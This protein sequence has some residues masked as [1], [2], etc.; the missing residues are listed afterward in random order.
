MLAWRLQMGHVRAAI[1]VPATSGNR[2]SRGSGEGGSL[3]S[4]GAP[5]PCPPAGRMQ[6]LR[7]PSGPRPLFSSSQT[8]RPLGPAL[9]LR[10]LWRHTADIHKNNA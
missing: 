4:G 3:L 7:L 9:W 1:P 8:S 2:C 5:R 6:T 10:C